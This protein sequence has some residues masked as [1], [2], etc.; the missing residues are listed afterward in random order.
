MPEA[1]TTQDG[2]EG[3]M[4]ETH[5]GLERYLLSD[6]SRRLE[7]WLQHPASRG[8][9]DKVERMESRMKANG[10]SRNGDCPYLWVS[11]QGGDTH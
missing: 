4:R 10:V 3:L 6:R 5:D 1:A 7:M 2:W 8:R 9:F 11:S